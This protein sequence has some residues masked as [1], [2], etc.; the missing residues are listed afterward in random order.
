MLVGVEGHR[1][2]VPLKVGPRRAHVG[3]GA[4]ALDHLDVHKLAGGI[5]DEDQERALRTAALEPPVLGAVDLD[6]LAAA[7]TPVARLIRARALGRTVLP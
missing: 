2:A 6:E 1:L 5:V 3:E 4:L 7:V